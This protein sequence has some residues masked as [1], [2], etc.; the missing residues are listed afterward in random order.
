[1]S[2]I[3]YKKIKER[4]ALKNLS[5]DSEEVLDDDSIVLTINLE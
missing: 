4:L 5:I 3:S 1:M 2:K